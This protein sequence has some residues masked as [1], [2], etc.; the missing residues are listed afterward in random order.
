MRPFPFQAT[1]IAV[2]LA[3]CVP[4]TLKT[5]TLDPL[6]LVFEGRTYTI[7]RSATYYEVEIDGSERPVDWREHWVV[8]D[9]R[10]GTRLACGA[11]SEAACVAVL[12]AARGRPAAVPAPEGGGS[13]GPG[14]GMG[15]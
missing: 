12:R 11:A 14:G 1:M 3:A 8:V 2:G 13:D 7:E 6:R 4:L 9:T 5:A 15:Y 10:S